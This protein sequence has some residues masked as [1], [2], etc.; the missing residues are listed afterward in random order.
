M[1]DMLYS[2]G[3]IAALALG[4]GQLITVTIGLHNFTGW[5]YVFTVFLALCVAI[6]PLIGTVAAI[7][8]APYA[9]QWTLVESALIFGI[10]FIVVMLLT[11]NPDTGGVRPSMSHRPKR[12]G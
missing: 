3:S 1:R 11:A 4:L 10:G 9:W 7:W 12:F 5:H 6:W 8:A 2:L